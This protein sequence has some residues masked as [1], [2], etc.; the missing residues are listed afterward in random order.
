MKSSKDGYEHVRISGVDRW[1]LYAL[2]IRNV[3][4]SSSR[5]VRRCPRTVANGNLGGHSVA[6]T[7]ILVLSSM[8]RPVGVF[9]MVLMM[10]KEVVRN[11]IC[12]ANKKIRVQSYICMRI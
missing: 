7:M 3:G 11:M 4:A 12:T 5:I 9:D 2:P 6:A 1:P 8:K 10:P